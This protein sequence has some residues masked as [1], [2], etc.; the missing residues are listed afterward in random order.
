MGVGPIFA[1]DATY[2]DNRQGQCRNR[3]TSIALKQTQ[4]TT[5]V[6]V[7]TAAVGQAVAEPSGV[8]Y[9]FEWEPVAPAWVSFARSSALAHTGRS[10]SHQRS[11]SLCWR[12]RRNR[13]P[14]I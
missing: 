5:P 7:F 11:P 4:R 9:R 1:E 8:P 12:V 14:A 10:G 6:V 13:G 2:R 3:D